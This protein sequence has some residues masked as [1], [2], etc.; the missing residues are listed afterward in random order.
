MVPRCIRLLLAAALF[1]TGTHL[2]LMRQADCDGL[3]KARSKAPCHGQTGDRGH[4]CKGV[5]LTAAGV[6]SSQA[7]ACA[8]RLPHPAC[9]LSAQPEVAAHAVAVQSP[10]VSIAGPPQGP[11]PRESLGRSP[12]ASV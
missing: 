4:C 10:Q 5:H 1:W 12:P 9:L 2:C 6:S 11:P 7:L 3:V 8:P